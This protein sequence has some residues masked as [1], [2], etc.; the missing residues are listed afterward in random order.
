M[1]YEIEIINPAQKDIEAAVRYYE[2]LLPGLGKRFLT[3]LRII[4]AQL[5]VNPFY[6]IKYNS[7]RTVLM[8]IFPYLIHFLV[9]VEKKR[10]VILAIVYAGRKPLDYTKRE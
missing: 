1:S 7:V 9:I 6:E 2:E 8:P 10:V 5:V 4:S 3:Q